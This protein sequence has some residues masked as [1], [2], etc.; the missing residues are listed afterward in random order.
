[1]PGSI[2]SQTFDFCHSRADGS[3]PIDL[4]GRLRRRLAVELAAAKNAYL[5]NILLDVYDPETRYDEAVT[6]AVRTCTCSKPATAPARRS[7]TLFSA[8][9]WKPSSR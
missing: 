2:I 3:A 5:A 6:K 4:G 9:P 8:T 1:V 7:R